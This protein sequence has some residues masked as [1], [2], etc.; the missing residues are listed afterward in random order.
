MPHAIQ[1]GEHVVCNVC[2]FCDFEIQLRW[3]HGG[4]AVQ[5]FVLQL[6]LQMRLNIKDAFGQISLFTRANSDF[7][8]R[9]L[10]C[11]LMWHRRA[12]RCGEIVGGNESIVSHRT[13]VEMEEIAWSAM[14]LNQMNTAGRQWG[15]VGVHGWKALL[16]FA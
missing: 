15:A 4:R 1:Q 8:L 7:P 12:F 6:L 13:V 9:A 3:R 5:P 16:V 11:C 10:Q 14:L 2:D